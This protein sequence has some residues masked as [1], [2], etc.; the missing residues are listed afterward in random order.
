[1]LKPYC[2]VAVLVCAGALSAQTTPGKISGFDPALIDKSVSPCDDFYHYSCGLWIKDNPIPP[3]QSRWGRFNV[4]ADNNLEKL[5]S[6]LEEAAQPKPGRTKVEQQIGDYYASCMDEAGIEKL[7]TAPIESY[8][9]RVDK[10]TN[11][12]QLTSVLAF[13]H[14][15]GIPSV[16]GFFASPDYKNSGWMI[17]VV[18]Q[19]GLSLPDRDY[20][21]KDDAK[22]K[23]LREQ[24][25]AHVA[26]MFQ[27]MGD[28]AE[29]A[30]KKAD[31]VL[32]V[33]TALAK[34]SLDRVARRDP[35]NTYHKMPVSKLVT[36]APS[37]IGQATSPP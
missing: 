34:V 37:M 24:F 17:P 12:E 21:L 35:A 13:L 18:V 33:E 36:L 5:R 2:L 3:D 9:S 6:I 14:E 4:L 10:M 25:H 19:G 16:F 26:A 8:L 32:A 30:G 22:S 11:K 23:Q 20:Y 29:D 1:M 28:S 15:N 27:L 31:A 7:G